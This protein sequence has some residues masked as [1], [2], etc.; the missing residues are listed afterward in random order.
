MRKL[1]LALIATVAM[2]F[3]G[4][5]N[6][7]AQETVYI[8]IWETLKKNDSK[9]IVIS[10]TENIEI[11]PIERLKLS[12]EDNETTNGF[13]VKKEIDKWIKQGFEIKTS[14]TQVRI[15]GSGVGSCSVTTIILFK[16]E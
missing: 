11:I 9:I 7:K 12:M 3:L 16:K 4:M 13:Y 2:L 5:S 14:F 8:E 6:V 15:N 1:R 10:G